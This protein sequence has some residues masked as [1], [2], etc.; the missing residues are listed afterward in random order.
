MFLTVAALHTP[1]GSNDLAQAGFMLR[2]YCWAHPAWGG[3]SCES[4]RKS[5]PPY[6]EASKEVDLSECVGRV[7]S[8]YFTNALIQCRVMWFGDIRYHVAYMF[9]LGRL[10]GLHDKRIESY[11]LVGLYLGKK[12][13]ILDFFTDE[14]FLI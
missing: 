4:I 10:G 12:K 13:E 9:G 3:G 7:M 14:D 11:E 2:S 8:Y 6:D 1:G 5:P